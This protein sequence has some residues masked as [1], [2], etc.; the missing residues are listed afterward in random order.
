MLFCR[1]VWLL[2]AA[3]ALHEIE[4]WNILTWYR[5]HYGDL[6][7][8]TDRTVRM[9]LF[10]YVSIGLLWTVVALRV[11]SRRE[12]AFALLP[13][14][15]FLLT[16]AFQHVYWAAHLAA[17]DPG[18]VTAVT[19]LVPVTGVLIWSALRQR[20]VPTWYVAALVLINVPTV[21]ETIRGDG[22]VRF[23]IEAVNSIGA[24]LGGLF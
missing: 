24:A 8:T 2:P 21:V 13:L 16:N 6:P 20:L 7:E 12:A 1:L 3:F 14:S 9:G 10:A 11:R 17:Y 22:I 18:L 5:Q 19:L 23:E 15:L 4:E